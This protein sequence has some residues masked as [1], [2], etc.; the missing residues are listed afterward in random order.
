MRVRDFAMTQGQ[1]LRG[2][3]YFVSVVTTGLWAVAAILMAVVFLF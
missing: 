2:L 3:V 1:D